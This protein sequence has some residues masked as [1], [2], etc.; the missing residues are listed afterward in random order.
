MAEALGLDRRIEKYSGKKLIGF[1]RWDF[2][3]LLAVTG[4]ALQDNSEYPDKTSSAYTA[5]R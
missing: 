1:Y 5:L 2:D 3:C 4:N